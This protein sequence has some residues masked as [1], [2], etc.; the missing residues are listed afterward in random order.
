MHT[1]HNFCESAVAIAVE[2]G[3]F[4]VGRRPTGDTLSE[5]LQTPMNGNDLK[6]RTDLASDTLIRSR[7]ESLYP[8]HGLISEES[9]PKIT[10]SPYR[11][12]VDP[13]DGT[14]PWLRRM[15]D[16]YAV[17]I[18]LEHNEI[19]VVGVINAA[20]LDG[21]R[22][23]MAEEGRG[24]FLNGNRIHVSQT[25]VVSEVQ[26]AVDYGK[27]DKSYILELEGKL[28]GTTSGV[29]ALYKL[30]GSSVGCAL[31]ASG[32]LDAALM[33]GLDHWDLAAAKIILK[34]AGAKVTC[35][36]GYNGR[37]VLLA[38][39]PVLHDQLYTLINR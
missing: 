18:A 14:R 13:L 5:I 9:P 27:S 29:D 17:S 6:T 34:E 23:Y 37:E 22:C 33:Y 7:L 36:A 19:P 16:H 1:F 31:V 39:N 28:F 11:W 20:S 2:A 35:W 4:L 12:V 25:S 15:S 10:R 21:G 26:L 24:A 8:E 32:H 30:G 3:S 38:A